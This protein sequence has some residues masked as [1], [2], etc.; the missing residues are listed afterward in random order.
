MVKPVIQENGFFKFM[1]G[2]LDLESQGIGRSV[3][4]CPGLCSQPQGH[5]TGWKV[6]LSTRTIQVRHEWSGPRVRGRN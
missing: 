3:L 1:V 6:P 2:N 5:G 4:L